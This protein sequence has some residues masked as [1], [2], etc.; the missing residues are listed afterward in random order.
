MIKYKNIMKALKLIVISLL[1]TAFLFSCS[2]EFLN[3]TN[4]V[5]PNPDNF[6]NS[7]KAAKKLL[8]AT[9]SPW[10]TNTQMYG[11]RFIT[12]CDALTDD[13]GLRLNGA[14]LVQVHEWEITPTHEY[15]R[16]WWMYAYQSVNAANYAIHEI[17]KSIN[18]GMTESIMNPYIAEARFMRAFSYMFLVS[19]YGEV[20]LIDHPLSSFKEFSQP[21]ASV[22]S[23]WALIES[24]LSYAKENLTEDG[25][26]YK[27][28]PVKATAAAYLAKAYLYQQKYSDAETTAREAVS[29]ASSEGFYLVDDYESIFS[30]DNEGN[31]ELLFYLQYERNNSLWEN[32]LPVE[33]NVRELPSQFQHIQ[34]GEGWGYRLPARDLYDAFEPDDPRRGYTIYAPGDVFGIYESKTP[35][36]Y[37]H[38]AYNEE[39]KE[40]STQITYNMGDTVRYDYRWSPT[41]MNVRKLTENLAGLTNVRY[42]GL[43]R[44]LM[45]VADLYLILAEALAEQGDKEALIWVNKV[46]ARKSVNMPPKTIADGTL[47]DIVRHERR[48][49][50]AMEGHRIFDLFRWNALKTVFGIGNGKKVKLHFY[51]DYLPDDDSNKY[52]TAPGL[53]TYPTDHILF[54]IPQ[55]EIDQNNSITNNNPGY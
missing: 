45:R 26:G 6:L 50:L 34:G 17:S 21:R 25:G 54:P 38:K 37:T 51:S 47:R 43:D 35:F 39:G 1:S 20:P 42:A 15:P 53:R 55:Y 27:G 30:V 40:F 13:S 9:Y 3:L 31:P 5:R 49:E 44:P 8:V 22:D 18:K 32:D 33:S 46:R 4:K 41:G 12:I 10:V 19:F 52:K 2:D 23:I 14:S 7:E 29:L 11:K 28:T 36:T 48:V 16:D 24:D